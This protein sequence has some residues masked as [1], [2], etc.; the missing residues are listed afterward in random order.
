MAGKQGVCMTT[1][2]IPD[3]QKQFIERMKTAFAV[4]QPTDKGPLVLAVSD[5]FCKLFGYTDRGQ[6]GS[7]ISRNMFKDVHPEDTAGITNAILR[8]SAED[9]PLEVLYR[10]LKKDGTGY[11]VIRMIGKHEEISDGTRLALMWFLD[12]GDYREEADMDLRSSFRRAIHEESFSK[13]LHYDYLTGLPNLSYFFELAE[14]GRKHMLDQGGA[15]ALLYIDLSGMKHYNHKYGF[16]EGDKMLRSFARLLS[17]YFHAEHCCHIGADRFAAIADENGLED[18]LNRMFQEWKQLGEDKYLSIRVG[19]FLNR[20]EEVPAGMAYD[21]AKMACDVIRETYASSFRYFSHEMKEGLE[22]RQFI[23]DDF[24]TA[25]AENWIQVYYQSIIRSVSGQ[26]CDI[27]ALARWIDPER[28]FLSPAEFIPFLEEAGLIYRLDLYVLERVLEN[29]KIEEKDGIF[30]IPHSINLSRSDFDACDM[31]EEIRRRVDDAGVSRDMISIEITESI[32]GSDFE[33]MKLQVERFR[34]LGFPVW[35]DDFGSG[36][37]SLDVLQSIGFDLIK[38][39]MGFLRRLDDGGNGKIILTELMRMASALGLDTICE[40]VETEEHVRFL[41]EIG[42]SKMQG[43]YFGRPVPFD[44]IRKMAES[45]TLIKAEKPEESEYYESLSRANL[46]DLRTI[47]SEETDAFHNV[48][49]TLPAAIIEICNGSGRIIRYSRSYQEFVRRFFDD[50]VRDSSF[51]MNDFDVKN[52]APFFTYINEYISGTLSPFFDQKMPDG[53]VIH[54]FLRRI[55]CNPATGCVAVSIAILSVTDPEES[56][57][58]ADIAHALAADYYNM[59]VIDLDTDN[60]IEY[61]SNIGGEELA[62]VRRG[63]DFFESAKRDTMVRIYQKDREGFLTIFTRENVL[64]ELDAQGVFTT[65]YRLIDTGEPMYVNMKVTRMRG[66]NRII[67]GISIIDAQM[68][69]QEADSVMRQERISFGRIAALS[70]DYIVLYTVDPE[71]GRYMQYNPSNEFQKFSL[72]SRGDDF[73]GDVIRDAQKAIAPEDMERH[74]R[75]MTRENMLQVMREERFLVHRY[76]L[77]LDGK[78][79]PVTLR[80][81]I[82][83]E[84]GERLIILGVMKNGVSG[85]DA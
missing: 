59:F 68:K 52:A 19:I 7:D 51:E 23:L 11:Q 20:T 30:V 4:C 21:R 37:S 70:P 10:S 8:F 61:S 63:R 67:L 35:M 45:H 71:T 25:L 77:L 64:K 74:L 75:V 17:S 41:R 54:S 33:F 58:Y 53:S 18:N 66:G 44:A 27:E 85:T 56:T 84:N 32:I 3:E 76:H 73:F 22:N 39:D 48:F 43:Y 34:A 80:A 12:E 60:F 55:G 9:E 31:V 62:E 13:A 69:Q 26:V 28:G 36:Y 82:V 40:G 72:A 46:Y 57:T 78:P 6:A 16:A 83:E 2:K 47:S 38:F 50:T 24:E 15:P 5:G 81:T 29:I 14:V 1:Y 42:C 79:V 49:E 65:T